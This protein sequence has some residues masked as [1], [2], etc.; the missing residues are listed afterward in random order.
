M[1]LLPARLASTRFENKILAPINN[2]PM[3][4]KTAFQVKELD[5]VVICADDENVV[6]I[7]KKYDLK[8]ILT[9]KSHQSGTERINEAAEILGLNENEII[10]NV[11]ADEP[12]IEP[13]V[14]RKLINLSKIKLKN[15]EILMTS[16]YKEVSNEAADDINLVKVVLDFDE[17][18]LYFSRS[19]VPYDR[20]LCEIYHAHIGLYGYTRK[21]LR[22]YCTFAPTSLENTEKLEQLRVLY[23]GKKI[24]LT[25]VHTN[26]FGIDTKE[27]LK[28]A[29]SF[30]KADK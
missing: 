14:V 13:E 28:R 18:A 25:K 30:F 22:Q 10:I 3:F 21:S 7:A 19:K 17:N 23:H 24:A 29:L 16:C 8:A 9:S 15:E 12:F 1:I 20:D 5:E 2:L 27:D 6:K 26:S 11:Q 4:V